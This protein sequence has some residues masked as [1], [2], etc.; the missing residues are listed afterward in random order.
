MMLTKTTAALMVPAVFWM[1]W[2]AMGR[3]PAGLLS[4]GEHTGD[5][6]LVDWLRQYLGRPYVG[7]VHRLSRRSLPNRGLTHCRT[8]ARLC[9]P[10]FFD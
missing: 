6:N 3:K 5:E 2:S 10:S 7:L 1:A 8:R 9:R 4:Q